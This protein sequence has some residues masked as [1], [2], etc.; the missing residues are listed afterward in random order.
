MF[1]TIWTVFHENVLTHTQAVLRKAQFNKSDSTGFID[2]GLAFLSLDNTTILMLV[3]VFS[4]NTGT[5]LR[6][7]NMVLTLIFEK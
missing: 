2:C 6:K 4:H 7:S 3:T 5:I 1:R